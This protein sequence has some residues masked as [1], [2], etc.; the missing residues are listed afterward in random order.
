[1]GIVKVRNFHQ[2]H[3]DEPIIFELSTP[4][5]R[6][7]IP[8]APEEEIES[9]VGNVLD[10]IPAAVRRD[11]PPALPELD[12]KSV[13]AHYLRLSQETLGAN[14]CNDISEGTCTMKYN[15]RINEELA[16]LPGIAELHPWQ[17]EETLQ[18]ILEIYYKF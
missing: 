3:W 9:E 11:T 5:L 7:V 15:P 10:S 12:Q 16:N 4:G 14:I 18:G 17:D 6:G 8:P 13:L 2:A 1:M